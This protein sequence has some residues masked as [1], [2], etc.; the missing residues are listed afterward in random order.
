MGVGGAALAA[1]ISKTL[2]P[3]L[4]LAY[5][6]LV[7][8]D[9]LRCWPGLFP[10]GLFRNWMPMVWL[11]MHG[12]LMTLYE[13]LAFEILTFST[14]YI[15]TAYLA[16]QTILSMTSILTWHIPFSCSVAVSTRIGQLIGHGALDA[17]RRLTRLYAVVFIVIGLFDMTLLLAFKD[18]IPKVFTDE[19]EVQAIAAKAMPVVAAFQ[20]FDATTSGITGV[21]RGLGRQKIAS[22]ASLIVYYLYAVPLALA[23][24]LGPLKLGLYGL[25]A[26]L[27][28]GLMVLTVVQSVILRIMN[29]QHCVDDARKRHEDCE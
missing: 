3:I 1:A 28:S 5:V 2:R 19:V 18:F 15:G 21:N 29:W 10:S 12:A 4:L 16:A 27:G 23:L 17:T 25:W 26:A 20:F 24:E 7:I 9:T 14:S 22:W 6:C 13:Y 8:P 11:S